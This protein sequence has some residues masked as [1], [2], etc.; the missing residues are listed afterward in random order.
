M[1]QRDRASHK[2][3]ERI[4][5]KCVKIGGNADNLD[6]CVFENLKS[7]AELQSKCAEMQKAFPN[8]KVRPETEKNGSFARYLCA[9][10]EPDL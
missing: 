2:G 10:D 8:Y 4:L 3:P 5:D 1:H 7:E 9:L 6:D